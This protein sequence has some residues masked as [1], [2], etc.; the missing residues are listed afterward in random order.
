MKPGFSQTGLDQAFGVGYDKVR[1]QG[2]ISNDATKA[3]LQEQGLLGTG[4][5]VGAMQA[6]AWNTEQKVADLSRDV[7]IANEAQ[8]RD[9]FT[10]FT[11]S[12]NKL[13]QSGLTFEQIREAINAARRNESQ[14]SLALLLQY[15]LG[16]GSM[17][18]SA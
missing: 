17:Y 12:A 4:T 3:A 6:N 1:R 16:T 11:D 9:D 8:K 14:A 10:S 15:F 5:E 7:F 2:T 13:F 18:N